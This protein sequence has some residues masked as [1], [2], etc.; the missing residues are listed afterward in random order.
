MLTEV[1]RWFRIVMYSL[2]SLLSFAFALRLLAMKVRQAYG[3]AAVLS[4][5]GLTSGLGAVL[6]IH[7]VVLNTVPWWQEIATSIIALGQVV[8][9]IALF[10]LFH[11]KVNNHNG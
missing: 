1:L 3:F 9:P 8:G 11:Q 7:W 6:V 2:A 4:A 10:W 5:L